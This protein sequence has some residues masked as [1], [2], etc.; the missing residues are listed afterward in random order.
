MD[1]K[2][3]EQLL[4]LFKEGNCTL[5]QEQLLYDFFT[6]DSSIILEGLKAY[7]AYFN[8]IKMIRNV[9]VTD[10]FNA[11]E[12]SETSLAQSTLANQEIVVEQETTIKKMTWIEDLWIVAAASVVGGLLFV[13]NIVNEMTQPTLPNQSITVEYTEEDAKKAYEEAVH[14]MQFVSEKL[15]KGKKPL[16]EI[17]RIENIN[18]KIKKRKY[19]TL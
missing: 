18:N 4:R 5:E 2:E 16:K 13:M 3:I 8:H 1:I 12:I 19:E 7:S 10:Q 15:N 17:K 11:S 9:E 6:S 14:I